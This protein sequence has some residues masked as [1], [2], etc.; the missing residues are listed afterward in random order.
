MEEKPLHGWR[1][2]YRF[3]RETLGHE[4]TEAT[5]YANHRYAEELN[6]RERGARRDPPPA[7]TDR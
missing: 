6:R 4:E 5:E 1:E 2:W 7:S 3:A